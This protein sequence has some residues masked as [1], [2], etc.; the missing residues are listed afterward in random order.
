LGYVKILQWIILARTGVP[1]AQAGVRVAHKLPA[2][3]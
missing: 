2:K 1:M 3:H